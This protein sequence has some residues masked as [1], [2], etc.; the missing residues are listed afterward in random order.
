M[1]LKG[2]KHAPKTFKGQWYYIKEF[3]EDYEALLAANNVAEAK[4]KVKLILCYCS[5]PVVEVIETLTH[6]IVPNWEELKKELLSVYDSDQLDQRYKRKH[7]QKIYRKY[8]HGKMSSLSHVKLYYRN[9]WR[10]AGFLLN[11]SK[12]SEDEYNLSS[13]KE[14]PGHSDPK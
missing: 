5:Y 3:I 6:F 13:C 8:R 12:I 2:S 14:F 1:P 7:L 9:F 4:D 10:V 11:K